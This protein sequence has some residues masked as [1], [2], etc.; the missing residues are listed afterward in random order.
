MLTLKKHVS[1]IALRVNTFSVSRHRL[2]KEMAFKSFNINY[3]AVVI[4][5]LFVIGATLRGHTI[6]TQIAVLAN[7]LIYK[8]EKTKKKKI[9]F[10]LPRKA[11]QTDDIFRLTSIQKSRENVVNFYQVILLGWEL[12]QRN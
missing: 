1:K 8:L 6:S 2:T 5:A 4:N 9:H 11:Q 12:V 10:L 3:L 7:I